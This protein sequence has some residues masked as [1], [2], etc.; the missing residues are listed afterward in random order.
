MM[1]RCRV[2]AL[3][4]LV[5]SIGA[6]DAAVFPSSVDPVKPWPGPGSGGL[7][8]DQI[9]NSLRPAGP[10]AGYTRGIRSPSAQPPSS[11]TSVTVGFSSGSAELSN[12]A[13]ATLNQA[14]K[15]LADHASAGSRI[16]V[17]GHSDTVG[18]RAANLALSERRASAVQQYLVSKFGIAQ[19]RLETVGFGA[20]SLLVA[21]PA[22]TPEAR[23]R[24]VSISVLDKPQPAPTTAQPPAEP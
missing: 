11:A 4:A 14:G 6:A 15:M 1:A 5:G 8:T 24:R 10:G 2:A 18:A 17:E 19:D 22:Q 3:V 9:I 13:R 16:L 7:T 23:N 21:T 20:D 12:E